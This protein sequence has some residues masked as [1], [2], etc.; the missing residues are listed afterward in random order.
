MDK[1]MR[2]MMNLASIAQVGDAVYAAR[3]RTHLL[4]LSPYSKPKAL[5]QKYAMCE[6]ARFQAKCL[7]YLIDIAFFNE[8]ELDII[9]RAKN[10]STQTKAKNASKEEYR[11]ATALEAIIGYYKLE[12]NDDRLNEIFEIIYEKCGE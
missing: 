2:A 5:H 8:D 4:H 3:V 7:V 11:F 10:K 9:N 1:E 6:S 12:Q